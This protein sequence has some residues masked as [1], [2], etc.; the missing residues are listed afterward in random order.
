VAEKQSR[1]VPRLRIEGFEKSDQ[2]CT[3]A[4][5]QFGN[6][7]CPRFDAVAAARDLSGLSLGDDFSFG[8][9]ARRRSGGAAPFE[10]LDVGVFVVVGVGRVAELDF[11]RDLLAGIPVGVE[12]KGVET[13]FA[14]GVL[15]ALRSC[16]DCDLGLLFRPVAGN[17]DR[18]VPVREKPRERRRLLRQDLSR[19][20]QPVSV[21]LPA[22]G[23]RQPVNMSKL[24][25]IFILTVT[26]LS[27]QFAGAP[28]RLP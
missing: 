7:S 19:S 18:R 9:A 5:K 11:E 23:V 20:Q 2:G 14:E 6:K 27:A 21:S 4:G 12:S 28:R 22:R 1:I 8:P 15:R 17:A 3:V 24:W 16:M 25:L 26:G 10:L 13:F